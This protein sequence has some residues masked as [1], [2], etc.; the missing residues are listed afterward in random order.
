[1]HACVCVCV[2]HRAARGVFAPQVSEMEVPNIPHRP[3]Q[4]VHRISF[5]PSDLYID[6]SDFREVRAV[7]YSYEY[8]RVD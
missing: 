6:R 1:M 5:C 2:C 8:C 3:D 4:G 7:M